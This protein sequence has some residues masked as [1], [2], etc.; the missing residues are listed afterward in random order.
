MNPRFPLRIVLVLAS[1][2]CTFVALEIVAR[3]LGYRN[4]RLFRIPPNEPVTHVADPVLG[5]RNKP[6]TYEY[7]GYAAGAPAVR[8][9]ILEDGS[10]ATGHGRTTSGRELWLVGCSFTFGHALGDD[11]SLGW[12]LQER[13][14]SLAVK[15]H[16][17]SGYGTYQVLLR[18][19]ELLK[20]RTEAPIIVYGFVESHDVRSVAG[21]GWLRALAQFSRSG[22]IDVPYVTLSVDGTLERH[23]PV[24]YPAW[25][26]RNYSALV[27][28]VADRAVTFA[29]RARTERR[30]AATESL[31]SEMNTLAR[32]HGGTLL[33]A[34]LYAP[35]EAMARIRDEWRRRGI[36]TA[37]CEPAEYPLPESLRVPGEAHPKGIVNTR[38]A[39]CISRSVAPILER[40]AATRASAAGGAK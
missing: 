4:W 23:P 15:N 13:L 14:P 11:E 12:Q 36:L 25:P 27:T 10:R 19:E 35:P 5:W 21:P 38:W 17:V 20:D 18:L 3:S 2:L 34:S 29:A 28:M 37:G 9:T 1:I 33:V 8:V 40:A 30:W 16:A 6:G 31:L 24:R 26:L 32:A 39:D 7:P 22:V